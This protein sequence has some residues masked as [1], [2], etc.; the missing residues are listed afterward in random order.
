MRTPDARGGTRAL[1]LVLACS[2]ALNPTPSDR[3]LSQEEAISSGKGAFA[4]VRTLEG[5]SET[6]ELI[7]AS[8][9]HLLLLT[10]L[11]HLIRIDGRQVRELTLG[12]HDNAENAF[13][14]WGVLGSL[15]T[16]S[17]GYFLIFSFPIWLVSSIGATAQESRRGLF[18]CPADTP[19]TARTPMSMSACL[20][21]AG[22]YS[23]FPQGLPPGVGR[24]Q[25]LGRA[26]VLVPAPKAVTPIAP[27]LPDAG[28]TETPPP[29]D[30]PD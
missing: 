8:D 3:R 1:A 5:G 10:D 19:E 13:L 14:L 7:A 18:S 22:A 11:G 12:V 9:D 15:S 6:G 30:Q 25:L 2:C 4:L 26:P 28:A 16:I 24:D 23:R 29:Y 21:A 17:H 27:P 20:A